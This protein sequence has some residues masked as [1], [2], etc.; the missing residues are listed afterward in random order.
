M[1]ELIAMYALIYT[2]DNIVD[3]RDKVISVLTSEDIQLFADWAEK[4]TGT[5]EDIF[6]SVLEII[7]NKVKELKGE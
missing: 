2:V 6:N 1:N 5:G 3:G 7:V 4:Q